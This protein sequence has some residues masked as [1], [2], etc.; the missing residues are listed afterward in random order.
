[1]TTTGPDLDTAALRWAIGSQPTEDLVDIACEALVRGDDSP[2]LRVLAG[3]PP[4]DYWAIKQAFDDT[5]SELGIRLL[6]EQEALWQLARRIAQQIVDGEIAP[7]HGAAQIWADIS[8]RIELE[9]DFRIFIGLSS[10]YEDHPDAKA[11][12]ERDTVK[13]AQEL[14]QRDRPRRWIL[15]TARRGQLPLASPRSRDPIP[16]DTLPI[17]LDLVESLAEWSKDYDR[18]GSAWGASDRP[19]GRSFAGR[20]TQDPILDGVPFLRDR[21]AHL[22]GAGAA[23][24]LVRPLFGVDGEGAGRLGRLASSSAMSARSISDSASACRS[25]VAASLLTL[26]K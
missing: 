25:T 19:R 2:S 20:R 6:A 4:D 7:L 17:R 24:D 12:L 26:P 16:A 3:L 15:L 23:H 5:L 18:S 10:E 1:V 21:P 11:E 14:L 13:A 9:G 8:N 22:D